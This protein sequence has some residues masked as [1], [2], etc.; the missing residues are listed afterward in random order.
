MKYLLYPLDVDLA[1]VEFDTQNILDL[2]RLGPY[3]K[4]AGVI[5]FDGVACMEPATPAMSGPDMTYIR[6]LETEAVAVKAELD[7]LLSLIAGIVQGIDTTETAT[8]LRDV[9]V[10]AEEFYPLYWQDYVT[11]HKI[12]AA[13]EATP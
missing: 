2:A 10:G 12:A 4:D 3:H 8:I 5:I 11:L 13:K 6:Q 9:G 1:P 7:S